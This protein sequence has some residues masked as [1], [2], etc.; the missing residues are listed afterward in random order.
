M[1]NRGEISHATVKEFDQ[2][3]K[4]KQLPEH[5]KKSD[6]ESFD[7][8]VKAWGVKKA[9]TVRPDAGFGSV[10]VKDTAPAPAAGGKGFGSVVM[11]A[12]PAPA[13]ASA[14]QPPAP[15][16]KQP[17]MPKMKAPKPPAPKPAA[18]EMQMSQDGA[19]KQHP[20][21]RLLQ[22]MKNRKVQEIK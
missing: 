7:Q 3:S 11:K 5:V 1:E 8:L 10:T 6:V 20:V 18:P 15:K 17:A 4:G 12:G 14:P 22:H 2:A 19:P 13:P 9:D 16:M 21:S